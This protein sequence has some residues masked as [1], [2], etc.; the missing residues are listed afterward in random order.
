[1]FNLKGCHECHKLAMYEKQFEIYI[2]GTIRVINRTQIL[3]LLKGTSQYLYTYQISTCKFDSEGDIGEKPFDFWIHGQ[4]LIPHQFKNEQ[5]LQFTP[6]LPPA[7]HP[8]SLYDTGRLEKLYHFKRS[9][10]HYLKM[11]C[12]HIHLEWF[13]L[14]NAKHEILLMVGLLNESRGLGKLR[15]FYNR[16]QYCSKMQCFHVHLE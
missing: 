11:Q 16:Y 15:V 3:K 8:R 6:P 7:S 4:L 1:M 5:C 2:F 14:K 12:P 10:W 9:Y 13:F